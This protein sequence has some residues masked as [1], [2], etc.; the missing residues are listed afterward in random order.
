[1]YYSLGNTSYNWVI[2]Y[3]KAIMNSTNILVTQLQAAYNKL[4]RQNWRKKSFFAVKN[5]EICMCAHGAVRAVVSPKIQSILDKSISRETK[6]SAASF[7]IE[8]NSV[9]SAIFKG[10]DERLY[11]KPHN[12]LSLAHCTPDMRPHFVLGLVGLTVQFNDYKDTTF[13]MIQSKFRE[14]IELAKQLTKE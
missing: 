3:F 1:M 8:S 11:S 4:T 10:S 7:Y 5:D 13:E 6:R 12:K 9:Y 14:A 2:S